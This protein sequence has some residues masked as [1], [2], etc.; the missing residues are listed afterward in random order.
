MTLSDA[1]AGGPWRAV[2]PRTAAWWEVTQQLL[3]YRS[4]GRCEGCGVLF[5][6]GRHE[7]SI[8]HRRAGGQGGTSRAD[9]HDLCNLVVLCAEWARGLAGV[10]GCHGRAEARLG[11]PVG[12]GLVVPLAAD[13][14][15]VPVTLF[16]G[17]RVLLARTSPDYLPPGDGVPYAL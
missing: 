10:L 16:S 14:A 2:G 11:D 5:A 4:G 7:L 15:A 3:V 1:P 12:R 17:R 13:P 9:Q 6:A 8:H